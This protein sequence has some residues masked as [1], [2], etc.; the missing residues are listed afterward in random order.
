MAQHISYERLGYDTYVK[1]TES[2][3]FE[4]KSDKYIFVDIQEIIGYQFYNPVEKKMFI[5]IHVVLL[6]KVFTLRETVGVE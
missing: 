2:N 3:K 5:S 6:E 4:T 1:R